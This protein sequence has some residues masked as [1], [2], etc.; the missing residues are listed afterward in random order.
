MRVL[1][2][3][4]E[5]TLRQSKIAWIVRGLIRAGQAIDAE[6]DAVELLFLPEPRRDGSVI[7]KTPEEATVLLIP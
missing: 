5:G 2:S 4:A 7:G 3:P 6:A 1:V